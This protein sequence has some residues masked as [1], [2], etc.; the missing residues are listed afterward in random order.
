MRYYGLYSAVQLNTNAFNDNFVA[1]DNLEDDTLDNGYGDSTLATV[2]CSTAES[3]CGPQPSCPY[4]CDICSVLHPDNIRICGRRGAHNGRVCSKCR[5]RV[6]Q[7]KSDES[8]EKPGGKSGTHLNATCER[9]EA[10]YFSATG[11]SKM[12]IDCRKETHDMKKKK[13]PA[14]ASEKK[15]H[16]RT[17]GGKV[18]LRGDCSLVPCSSTP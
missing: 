10:K 16:R 17:L 3:T 14:Y 2:T 11:K 8:G 12:C 15:R 9:C 7:N 4:P 18:L 5:I 13:K 6:K 1:C